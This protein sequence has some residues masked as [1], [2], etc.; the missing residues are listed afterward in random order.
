MHYT[1]QHKQNSWLFWLAPSMGTTIGNV[2][3][4]PEKWW[5]MPEPERTAM[6][7]HEKRHIAQGL[8][9]WQY[10]TSRQ[11]RREV[12]IEAYKVQVQFLLAHDRTP[13]VEERA[14]IMADGY[15]ILS[16]TTREEAATLLRGWLNG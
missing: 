16:W 9:W 1:I 2:I 15:G 7:E 10:L 14:S 3:Y 11:Y 13:K 5:A 12:E 8:S 6:L 4:F